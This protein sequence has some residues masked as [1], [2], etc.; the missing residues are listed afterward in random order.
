MV[1]FNSASEKNYRTGFTKLVT[2]TSAQL[3]AINTTPITI[4]TA[5]VNAANCIIIDSVVASIAA[6]T[7]YTS[8]HDL[9]IKYTN[10]SGATAATITASGFLDQTAALSFYAIPASVIPVAGAALVITCA[11]GDPATGT[12]AVKLRI[13]YRITQNPT[14]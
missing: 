1:A 14:F 5:P 13:R 9:L 12:A 3:L 7:A 8:I 2:V 11:T 10:A 4:M 6:G